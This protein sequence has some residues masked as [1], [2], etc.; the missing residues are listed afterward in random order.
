MKKNSIQS[1]RLSR[2]SGKVR[3]LEFDYSQ[4]TNTAS[5][6]LK[7]WENNFVVEKIGEQCKLNVAIDVW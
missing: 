4:D 2:S 5:G 3:R 6:D 1:S 7:I